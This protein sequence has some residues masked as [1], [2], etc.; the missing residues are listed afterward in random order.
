MNH[1]RAMWQRALKPA[2]QRFQ[3]HENAWAAYEIHK[4]PTELCTRWDYDAGSGKWERSETLIKME[5]AP[6][7]KG[8]MREC[9]RMKKMSQVNAHFFFN[10]AWEVQRRHAHGGSHSRALALLLL[11]PLSP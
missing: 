1:A 4:R 11:L 10:M 3:G 6:F 8:A 7:A 5:A 9:Y 2:L